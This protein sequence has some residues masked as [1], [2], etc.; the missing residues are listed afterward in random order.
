VSRLAGQ[1]VLVTGASR[2]TGRAIALAFAREGARVAVAARTEND[3]RATADACGE[4]AVPIVLDVTD[5]EACTAAVRRCEQELGR[6]DVL[7]HAAG[8]GLSRKFLDT[9]TDFWR[10]H[11]Q[12]DV[13]GPFWLTRA[14]VPA[15][16]ERGS[17][18]VIAIASLSSKLGF[19]YVAAYGAA[20][21][22]LL[23]LMRALA[24]E[25]AR[26]GVTFNCVCPHFLDTPM[27][28]VTIRNIVEKTGRTP[29]EARETLLTPQR[30]LVAP[31]EVAEVCLLLASPQGRGI[32]GQ[33]INV[34]G[35]LCFS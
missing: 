28:E 17:G 32:N 15:M 2:G 27:T 29:E 7:V 16:L 20:K 34:D 13:E 24:V 3:L 5:E 21:H 1:Q 19:A 10:F 18:A 33:A 22:A 9:D 25:Y 11:M 26:T 8:T 14:A 12:L 35:G 4:G 6:I 30:R 31:E 23:G